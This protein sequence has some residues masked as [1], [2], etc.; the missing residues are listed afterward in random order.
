MI[1]RGVNQHT[2]PVSGIQKTQ[3]LCCFSLLSLSL[4]VRPSLAEGYLAVLFESDGSQRETKTW[5]EAWIYHDWGFWTDWPA[6]SESAPAGP[7]LQAAADQSLR[8]V[9]QPHDG[10]LQQQHH[11]RGRLQGLPGVC[12]ALPGPAV[13]LQMRRQRRRLAWMCKRLFFYLE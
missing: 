8:Q 5:L 10:R 12:C 9:F 2:K 6:A 3:R 4:L 7:E 1:N 11:L 13:P